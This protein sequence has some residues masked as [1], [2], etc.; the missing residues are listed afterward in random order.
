MSREVDQR[1]LFE[2]PVLVVIERGALLRSL[3]RSVLEAQFDQFDVLEF[4][5]HDEVDNADGRNV[6]LVV[7]GVAGTAGIEQQSEALRKVV[8]AVPDTPVA[9]ICE[10][11]ETDFAWTLR[12]GIK[13]VIC[14]TT[15]PIEIV[16]PALQ[17]LLAGGTYYTTSLLDGVRPH[18]PRHHSAPASDPAF[19]GAAANIA[20]LLT[21]REQQVLN[22]ICNAQSNKQIARSLSI[23]ENTAKMHVR[24]I[25]SKLHVRTR[26]EAALL[27]RSPVDQ[28]S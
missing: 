28:A 6:R 14:S 5:G 8:D 17:L 13:G 9:L 27:F 20:V 25:L 18:G 26:I 23:S 10:T 11:D 7:V 19:D 1:A 12:A 4:A 2:R 16:I 24:R 15:T 22:Q 3:M 21:A